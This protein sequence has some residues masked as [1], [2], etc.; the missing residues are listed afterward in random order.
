MENEIKKSEIIEESSSANDSE[1]PKGFQWN[2]IGW[3]GASLGAV[4]WMMIT[5][6]FF[7]WPTSGVWSGI[8]GTLAIWSFASIAWAFREKISAFAGIISLIGVT[9][10]SNLGFLLF[11]HINKLP[12]DETSNR[13]ETNYVPYYGTLL[14]L[15]VSLL[16]F[17]WMKENQQSK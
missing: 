6:V 11:A 7:N 12:L 1:K 10:L 4:C 13:V 3:F 9:V 16:Y 8:V 2:L 14:I 5:P 15:F 17:F